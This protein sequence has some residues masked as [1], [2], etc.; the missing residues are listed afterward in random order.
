MPTFSDPLSPLEESDWPSRGRKKERFPA[1]PE[2]TKPN[3]M[4]LPAVHSSTSGQ[5]RDASE[6]CDNLKGD[7]EGHTISAATISTRISTEFDSESLHAGDSFSLSLNESVDQVNHQSISKKSSDSKRDRKSK[8]SSKSSSKTSKKNR[9]SSKELNSSDTIS[10]SHIDETRSQTSLSHDNRSNIDQEID[11]PDPNIL[12]QKVN[13]SLKSESQSHS[14]TCVPNLL[15]IPGTSKGESEIHISKVK[16]SSG[17]KSKSKSKSKSKKSRSKSS[18]DVFKLPSLVSKCESNRDT[19]DT[20]GFSKNRSFSMRNFIQD[21]KHSSS[22]KGN[23]YNRI[24]QVE[25]PGTSFDG[26]MNNSIDDDIHNQSNSNFQ[27]SYFSHNNSSYFPNNTSKFL[28]SDSTTSLGSIAGSPI[29]G[30]PDTRVIKFRSSLSAYAGG[31]LETEFL[32]KVIDGDERWIVQCLSC[33]GKDILFSKWAGGLCRTSI[34]YAAKAGKSEMCKI[35]LA[36]GGTDLL[37]VKDV[38]SRDPQYYAS[39]HNL[40]L[41]EIMRHGLRIDCWNFSVLNELEKFLKI[42]KAEKKKRDKSSILSALEQESKEA[43]Q[44]L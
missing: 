24:T 2:M 17:T 22:H 19:N 12:K 39:Q 10:L 20:G 9:S 33:Y 27:N 44:C 13:K 4:K 35:L 31:I 8:S 34:L 3:V 26:N 36:Y 43:M 30:G 11:S 32:Q 23:N 15:E 28:R 40:D 18:L 25:I 41:K 16:S 6:Y 37:Q 29:K 21:H 7:R 1:P 5:L 42:P 14:V 38:K